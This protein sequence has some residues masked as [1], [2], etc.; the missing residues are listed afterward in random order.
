MELREY[1]SKDILSLTEL[2]ADLGYP[3]SLKDM[4]ARMERMESNPNYRTFVSVKGEAVVGMVGITLHS[5]YTSN[6]LKVQITSVVTKKEYRGQGI[7]TTLLK[8]VEDWSIRSGATFI[9]LLS[10]I[11]DNRVKAHELYKTLGYEITGYRF[12]KR[13]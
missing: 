1:H 7:A 4:R 5:T 8:F 6:N 2:I 9:Y 10:G 11:N 13:I 12:V 3:S